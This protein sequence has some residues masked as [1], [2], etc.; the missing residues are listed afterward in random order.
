MTCGGTYTKI[1]EPEDYRKS[2]KGKDTSTSK[3]KGTS[4]K[5]KFGN[6]K[7][8]FSA[9]TTSNATDQSMNPRN[10][11]LFG[12]KGHHIKAG[13]TI[14]IDEE[15][16][17]LR[18]KIL[19][20]A[21]KRRHAE[22]QRG[23][24]RKFEP[25]SREK[26]SSDKSEDYSQPSGK[27]LRLSNTLNANDSVILVDMESLTSNPS[28]KTAGNKAMVDLTVYEDDSDHSRPMIDLGDGDSNSDCSNSVIDLGDD[29]QGDSIPVIDLGDDYQGDSIPVIDLGDD[30]QGDSDAS[31]Q[32]IG[33][34]LQFMMCPVC[35]RTDIPAAIINSHVAFC[36]DE[37]IESRTVDEDHL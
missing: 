22:D 24:K 25:T 16:A 1:K 23:I 34:G 8:I 32:S 20:A 5:V 36:L 7:E 14:T 26:Y 18:E 6:I 27:K 31:S 21:E 28:A 17:D 30:Y 37:D 19:A 29:Y 12:G 4:E 3:G 11:Q 13:N 35:G 10:T 15:R 2:K 9:G 33:N